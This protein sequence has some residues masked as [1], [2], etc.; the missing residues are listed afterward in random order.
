MAAPSINSLTLSKN[1]IDDPNK[2]PTNSFAKTFTKY[3]YSLTTH[4]WTPQAPAGPRRN[5][6]GDLL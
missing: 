2:N 1:P 5:S 4:R 6:S 3:G